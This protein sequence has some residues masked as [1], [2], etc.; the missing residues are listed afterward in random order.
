MLA[1]SLVTIAIAVPASLRGLG[2]D[3][4]SDG[5]KLRARTGVLELGDAQVTIEL[6][7]GVMPAG[8]KV[9]AIVVATAPHP[10]QIAVTLLAM[11]EL[12]FDGRRTEQ[13]PE[14]VMR[15]PLVL[16]AEPGGGPPKVV[17]FAVDRPIKQ[18]GRSDWYDVELV[19]K[20]GEVASTGIA[21]WSGNSFDVA[22]E[23]PATI[24]TEGPFTIA[25][26]VTNT[27]R[28]ALA[29]PELD[30]GAG[31]GGITDLDN[32]LFLAKPVDY[33]VEPVAP[34]PAIDVDPEPHML[35][36]GEESLTV[37]RVTPHH[38]G[39]DHFELV[40]RAQTHD[41]DEAMAVAAFDRPDPPSDVATR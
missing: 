38:L 22:I 35:A 11:H 37:Y 21:T 3:I 40:V 20:T 36:P 18:P 26:R 30:L 33:E 8:G 29:D 28:A 34:S 4:Q 23:P 14:L 19:S 13:P 2:A 9:S 15:R 6:D 5:P 7:R 31:F 10:R 16:D 1:S 25:V 39:V 17:T 41:G 27:T 32:H 24:P 12:G